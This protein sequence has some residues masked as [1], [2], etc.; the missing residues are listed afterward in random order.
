MYRAELGSQIA[1]LGDG[2]V[3]HNKPEQATH[4]ALSAIQS[5]VG[6]VVIGSSVDPH[7]VLVGDVMTM[8]WT[9]RARVPEPRA[10][11]RWECFRR[12]VV[13]EATFCVD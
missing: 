4:C 11:R 5:P 8:L 3:V 13:R 7:D 10:Q 12:D 2:I 6:A 9:V 1:Q